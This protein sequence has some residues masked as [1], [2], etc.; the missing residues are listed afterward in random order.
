VKELL[1]GI[2]STADGNAFLPVLM[3]DY[4]QRFGRVLHEVFSDAA[5]ARRH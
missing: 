3:A 1:R 4:T 5:C 2:S